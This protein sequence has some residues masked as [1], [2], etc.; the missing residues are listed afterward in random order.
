MAASTS[1]AL[2]G[3]VYVDSLGVGHRNVLG[4]AKSSAV[5]FGGKRIRS[6]RKAVSSLRNQC[7]FDVSQRVWE[8]KPFFGL[9]SRDLYTSSY[10]N[11]SRSA[12]ANVPFC[13]SARSEQLE[14]PADSRGRY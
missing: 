13:I 7:R 8:S 12:N 3:D 2:S 10:A 5:F 4:L 14:N 6:C 11:H 9:S 1:Q